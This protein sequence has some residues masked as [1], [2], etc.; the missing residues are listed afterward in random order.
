MPAYPNDDLARARE[1]L[2][3]FRVW[4]VAASEGALLPSC[5]PPIRD[6]L[7]K[8]P[9]REDGRNGSFSISHGGK[10]FKD[11][12][13]DGSSGDVWKF[14]KLCWPN[15]TDGELARKYIDMSGIIRTPRPVGRSQES[16]ARS[17]ETPVVD[18]MLLKAAKAMAKRDNV[19]RLEDAVYEDLERQLEPKAEVKDVPAWPDCVRDRFA[20]GWRVLKGAPARMSQLAKDRGWPAEWVCELVGFELLSYPLERWISSG[21]MVH[22]RQKAFRV[23]IPHITIHAAPD[24]NGSIARAELRP[25]GYHQRWFVPP[26]NDEP[27]KKGWLYIPSVPKSEQ[28]DF[29]KDL[30]TYGASL[31]VTPD[32]RSGLFPPLPFVLG[33]LNA[34]KVI[35]LLEGQWDAITFFG[36]CGYFEDANPPVGVCVFGIRGAQG[37]D[38][39]LAYWAK[40]IRHNK[41]L[42]WVIADND[43]AGQTWLRPPTAEEGMPRGPSFAERLEHVGCHKVLTSWLKPGQW[44][45]DFN[46]YYK[47]AKPGAAEMAAWMQR[48]G[49]M[50]EN[51]QWA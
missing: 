9:F 25:I 39:F 44:G 8:S 5:P 47:V 17:G 29:D 21:D 24:G 51:G 6:G 15:L 1:V 28:S 48:V 37:L 33:D 7:V 14:A 16:G 43:A 3:I 12:G 13:G 41:P 30:T 11:F 34:P 19:R 42:A 18:P 46:D 31:G 38:V 35:V 22:R 36:A 40:W 20:E 45:K 4:E 23:D 26:K 27:A 10:G 2:T 32:N 49:V 50:K